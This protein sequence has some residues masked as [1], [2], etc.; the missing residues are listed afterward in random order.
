MKEE[1]NFLYLCIWM[2]SLRFSNDQAL[3]KK[4]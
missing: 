1:G 4:K 3:D 2:F